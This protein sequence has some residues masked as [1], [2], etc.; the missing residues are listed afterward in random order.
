[1]ENE[2]NGANEATGVNIHKGK[3][4]ENVEIVVGL[5]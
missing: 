1:L 3:A 4:G 5:H 2:Y